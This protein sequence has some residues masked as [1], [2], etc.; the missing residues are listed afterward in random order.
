MTSQEPMEESARGC[1]AELEGS[2]LIICRCE[3]VSKREI[4]QAIQEGAT[5]VEEIKRRTRAGM[6]LCQGKTCSRLVRRILA[7]HKGTSIGDELPS[8]YRPPVRPVTLE[9]LA[10][11]DQEGASHA[12]NVQGTGVTL[13]M[14][15]ALDQ[16]GEDRGS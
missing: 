6:G 15:A 3:E 9:V 11:L 14:L 8:A 5:T 7:E 1:G 16:E 12:R 2:P 4:L 13:E 10:A